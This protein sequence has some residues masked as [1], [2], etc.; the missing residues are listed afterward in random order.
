MV[1]YSILMDHA[2]RKKELI[3]ARER[4]FRGWVVL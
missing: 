3:E 2:T 4:G 1:L